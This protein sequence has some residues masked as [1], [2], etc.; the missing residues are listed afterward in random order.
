VCGITHFNPPGGGAAVPLQ[1]SVRL[2]RA[3]QLPAVAE[4]ITS[5]A[6][7][8]WGGAGDAAAVT[9]TMG[10]I[11]P[12][13]AHQVPTALRLL[14]LLHNGGLVWRS[15]RLLKFIEDLPSVWALEDDAAHGAWA[16]P[17][18]HLALL[19]AEEALAAQGADPVG[20]AEEPDFDVNADNEVQLS[21]EEQP[22][23][24]LEVEEAVAAL[25]RAGHRRKIKN[26][27]AF[28]FPDG[29][30]KRAVKGVD[31]QALCSL[32]SGWA[33]VNPHLPRL[34]FL[35]RA[36]SPCDIWPLR[37]NHMGEL[38]VL[39][40]GKVRM[41]HNFAPPP[42]PPPPPAPPQPPPPP[43]PP[44][45]G[46]AAP[47]GGGG[48]APHPQHAK[49]FAAAARGD[50]RI[51][52]FDPGRERQTLVERGPF[53]DAVYVL[54]TRHFH[55]LAHSKRFTREEKRLL[56]RLT[57]VQ[58]AAA[59]RPTSFAAASAA[60]HAR[61]AH[62]APLAVLRKLAAVKASRRAAHRRALDSFLQKVKN[63]SIT[64]GTA[65]T[66]RRIVL[67]AGK[68]TF[69]SGRAP[70]RALYARASTILRAPILRN[71]E[72]RTS[73]CHNN[74]GGEI[75]AAPACWAQQ[76]PVFR[77]ARS[78]V[79]NL[80]GGGFAGNKTLVG[81]LRR[82]AKAI[83]AAKAAGNPEPPPLA[84]SWAFVECGG[85]KYC[86]ACK[87]FTSRDINAAETFVT[88]ME[89]YLAG[90]PRPAALTHEGRDGAAEPPPFYLGTHGA[91][92]ARA[93]AQV[94]AAEDGMGY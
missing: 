76:R 31:A 11:A 10:R 20:D 44:P 21:D 32:A 39:P 64:D 71:D 4:V 42:P 3:L 35:K 2:L 33:A 17:R 90:A 6:Q 65:R 1:R 18:A 59:Q 7:K 19:R 36:A 12:A 60:V 82:N 54:G 27:L 56:A 70:V 43:P 57:P 30:I 86:P 61:L 83:A 93:A 9:A 15:L 25:Q 8:L 37:A 69:L 49:I 5:L 52:G 75:N 51:I 94:G 45:A 62:P 55:Q 72:F 80:P 28:P 66:S 68:P 74:G 46:W 81:R 79:R 22:P 16:G 14:R 87:T 84:D 78:E 63:G 53:G 89:C 26:T 40:D 91:A 23:G 73:R 58:A 88:L 85:L 41:P 47:P 67:S 29:L 34:D 48:P 92:A 24:E 50:V 38:T 13:L 77:D